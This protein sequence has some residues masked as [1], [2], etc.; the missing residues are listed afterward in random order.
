MMDVFVKVSRAS[1]DKVKVSLKSGETV[2]RW[3][4]RWRAYRADGT[5]KSCRPR[6]ERS[7]EAE[8]LA[9]RLRDANLGRGGWVIG[10]D[11]YP[12]LADDMPAVSG[13]TLWGLCHAYMD[14]HWRTWSPQGRKSAAFV[15]RAVCRIVVEDAGDMPADAAAYLDQV[16]F[17][18]AQQ[19]F[20]SDIPA[21]VQW[22]GHTFTRAEL[23]AGRAWL[24]LRSLPVSAL[25]KDRV[26]RLVSVL[27]DGKAASSEHRYWTVLRHL[28]KWGFETDRVPTDLRV[29]IRVRAV[30]E[31]GEDGKF[32]PERTPTSVEM[33]QFADEVAV[34]HPRFRALPIVLGGAGLRI[35]EAAMLRR[36]HL[37]DDPTT[38]GMWIDVKQSFAPVRGYGT[39]AE[40]VRGTKRKGA[41]GN[42]KGRRTYLPPREADAVRAH[43][44]AHVG[45]GADE[46]V[47]PGPSGDPLRTDWLQR[48]VWQPARERAFPAPHRLENVGRHDFRHLACT[49]WLRAGVPFKTAQQW[50]GHRTLSVFLDVYQAALPDDS[51]AG[52]ALMAN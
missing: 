18:S 48:Q 36:R 10:G 24:D 34:T 28:L 19:A 47:F 7:L 13:P 33:W 39:D 30:D 50:S 25:T 4:V 35:G 5:S 9:D 40:M 46:L 21:S 23:A 41:T 52:A 44:A 51:A 32:D 6:F 16:A 12:T 37:S 1:V 42:L 38:R 2:T 31:T 11:G 29:G 43:L 15:L 14:A 45:P 8:A 26:Q 3:E 17:R 22:A 27:G 20:G 49:R